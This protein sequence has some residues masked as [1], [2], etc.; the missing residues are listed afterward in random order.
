MLTK[1]KTSAFI[2]S[3]ITVLSFGV[4]GSLINILIPYLLSSDLRVVIERPESLRTTGDIAALV[5]LIVTLLLMLTGV[6]AYWLYR[7]F[8]DRYYGP[9]GALR[10]SLFGIIFALML[11]LPAQLF[12][13]SLRLLEIVLNILGIFVAFFVARWLIP[14]ERTTRRDGD[15]KS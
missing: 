11:G 3:A 4:T 12:P 1:S 7:F 14:L 8:G 15:A 2:L 10:W 5:V 6:G 13:D 9:R